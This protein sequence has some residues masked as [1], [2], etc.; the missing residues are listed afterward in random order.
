[1]TPEDGESLRREVITTAL[2]M[3]A[4]GINVNTSGNLSARCVRGPRSGFVLTPSAIPYATLVP[5][6]LVFIDDS[7]TTS[8]TQPPSSEWRLHFQ[9]YA[10]RAD[11]DAIVHTHSAHATA[12]ACQGLD[13]PAFHYMVAVAGGADIRCARYETFGTQQLADSAVAAL[14]DRI[15]CLLAHHGVVACGK[16][17]ERALALAIEV[18]NLARTYMLTR[19][20]GEPKLLDEEEMKRVLQRFESYGR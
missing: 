19:S 3:N 15:A 5:A 9:I 2:A 6:D 10:A 4:S 13:I 8:G 12:L 11:V 1:M 14:E 7:G 20:L 18:E 17:L 16:N